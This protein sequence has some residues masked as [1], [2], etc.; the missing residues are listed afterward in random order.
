MEL[1]INAYFTLYSSP[2]LYYKTSE[3][4]GTSSTEIEKKLI[5]LQN[6]SINDR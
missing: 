4:T 6:I 5:I 3:T 1:L 2:V